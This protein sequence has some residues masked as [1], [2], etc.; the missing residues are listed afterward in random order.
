MSFNRREFLKTLTT[1]TVIVP[2][3]ACAAPSGGK[4]GGSSGKARIVVVGGGF[5]GATAAKYLKMMDAGLDVTLVERNKT[6]VSCPLSNEVI[7]GHGKYED[8]QAGYD[9][10]MKRGVNV[11]FDDAVAVDAAGKSVKL[12]SG[13]TLKYDFLVLSPGIDFNYGG[14][15]GYTEALANTTH[16]HAYKAGPQTLALKKQLEGMQ[17]GQTFVISVPPGPFRC[18]PGPYERASQ[19]ASYF[20]HHGKSKCKVL[21]A[22]A[23]DSFSKK[24]LFEQA[25]K[26]HYPGMIEWVAGAAGGKVVKFDAK[27]NTASSDFNDFKGDVVNIIPPHHAGNIAM[28]YRPGQRQGLVHRGHAHHGI[29]QAQGHLRGGRFHRAR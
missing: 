14:V 12:K 5:G 15:A 16:P 22:D 24:G 26:M 23:N 2:L 29:H 13:K 19:V 1:S 8:L 9:G 11:M 25:W 10:L 27:T 4:S 20:K 6:F 18:P 21:I 7:S 28:E 17:D 3:T